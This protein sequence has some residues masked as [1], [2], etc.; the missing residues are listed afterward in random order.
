MNKVLNEL[1]P[2]PQERYEGVNLNWLTLYVVGEVEKTRME[3]SFENIVVAAFRI[4]PKKFSLLGYPMFPDAKRV[5]DALWRCAYKDR[6][7]LRGKTSQ[8]FEFTE[9]GRQVLQ[10]AREALVGT[11]PQR[12]KTLSQTRRFERILDEVK[13]SPAYRRYEEGHRDAISEAECCHVLQ[14][15]LDSH[16][17]VLLDNLRQLQHIAD[18]LGRSDIVDLLNWLEGRFRAFLGKGN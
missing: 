15:T 16:R 13:R 8:G 14:G 12:K 3:L 1:Q 2:L 9:R 10:E 5:H 7:W 6:K 17:Q 4:F 18:D 11:V